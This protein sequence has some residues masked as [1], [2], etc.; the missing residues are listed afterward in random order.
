MTDDVFRLAL[1]SIL[2]VSGVS[3]WTSRWWWPQ[4]KKWRGQDNSPEAR[5]RA[6]IPSIDEL[7]VQF[8]VLGPAGGMETRNSYLELHLKGLMDDLDSLA[9]AY[10]DP[11]AFNGDWVFYLEFL[12]SRAEEGLLEEMRKVY[13]GK[14]K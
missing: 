12:R 10:P 5:F 6:L 9:I 11:D 7:L 8:G 4:W 14:G 2:T 13:R 1:A 3:V